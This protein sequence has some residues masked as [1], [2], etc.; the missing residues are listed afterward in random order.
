MRF[1]FLQRHLAEGLELRE[2]LDDLAP[3]EAA[4]LLEDGDVLVERGSE[5]VEHALVKLRVVD[6]V[7]LD[8]VYW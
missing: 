8:E 1:Q 5:L 6:D 3:L 2:Y 7:P 4:P